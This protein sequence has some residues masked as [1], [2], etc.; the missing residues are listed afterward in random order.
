MIL[1][2]LDRTLGSTCQ[3]FLDSQ[4]NTRQEG[5]LPVSYDCISCNDRL[6]SGAHSLHTFPLHQFNLGL[7][8]IQPLT[9]LGQSSVCACL[10]AVVPN[11]LSIYSLCSASKSIEI[12]ICACEESFLYLNI[13]HARS[14]FKMSLTLWKYVGKRKAF[15]EHDLVLTSVT[16]PPCK[17]PKWKLNQIL[18]CR[19]SLVTYNI[20]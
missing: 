5:P 18:F 19:F 8:H 16:E 6:I 7:S 4:C 2:S 3:T 14:F 1:D 17:E 15:S 20:K 13:T 10:S 12:C 11:F 9:A